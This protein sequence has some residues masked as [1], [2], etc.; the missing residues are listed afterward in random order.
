MLLAGESG[1]LL[2]IGAGIDLSA[3]EE[4]TLSIRPPDGSEAVTRSKSAGQLAVSGSEVAVE[5]E[6]R[7]GVLRRRTFAA[8]H[9]VEYV[10]QLADF[11]LSGEYALRLSASLPGGKHYRSRLQ[12]QRVFA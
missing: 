7:D 9:H 6:Q 1:K 3:A 4:I 5:I 10:T 12:L 11:P 8:G 2:R